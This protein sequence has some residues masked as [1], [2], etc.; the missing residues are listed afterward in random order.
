MMSDEYIIRP[1]ENSEEWN[2]LPPLLQDYQHE[3][4]DDTCF[5]TFD[6]EM[7]NIEQVYTAPG[8]HLLI[9][10][11]RSKNEIVGCVAMRTLFPGVAEMKRLYVVPDYRGRDIG[12]Q[13]AEKIISYADEK[14]NKSMVLDTMFEMRAAQKLYEQLGFTKTDAYNHQDL[15]KVICYEKK[16]R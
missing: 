3:F 13:L 14:E 7:A 15:S 5:T 10:I 6:A 16:L 1:P 4:D 2:Q 8:S 9:A 11:D 12:R